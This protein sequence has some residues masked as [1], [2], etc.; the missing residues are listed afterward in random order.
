MKRLFYPA[1]R[2]L[3]GQCPNCGGVLTHIYVSELIDSALPWRDGN[4]RDAPRWICR[5]CWGVDEQSSHGAVR[6]PSE[7]SRARDSA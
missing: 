6:S 7:S 4:V 1:E 2:P 5:R 3:S